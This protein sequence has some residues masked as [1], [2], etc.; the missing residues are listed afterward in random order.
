MERLE[1][2]LEVMQDEHEGVVNQLQGMK[3]G[4]HDRIVV[5]PETV[6]GGPFLDP[7]D[8]ELETGYIIGCSIAE[9]LSARS[10]TETAHEVNVK[11]SYGDWYL[12]INETRLTENG[13][14]YRGTVMQLRK[15]DAGWEIPYTTSGLDDG[16]E[17]ALRGMA[18]YCKALSDDSVKDLL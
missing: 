3:H 11:Q 14:H 13:S 8:E 1:K 12:D 16:A 7:G 4:R 6:D 9:E 17:T 10:P 15:S 18:K 5:E 2:A